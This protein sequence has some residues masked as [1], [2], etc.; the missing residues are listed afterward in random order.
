MNM[1][2]ISRKLRSQLTFLA[3]LFA[4]ALQGATKRQNQVH[5][6]VIS[7]EF[8][9]GEAP[10]LEFSQQLKSFLA[11]ND[12]TLQTTSAKIDFS[13][14][15]ALQEIR[16]LTSRNNP[17]VAVLQIGF[18]GIEAIVGSNQPPST[19]LKIRLADGL[20]EFIEA[21]RENAGAVVL[22]TPNPVR[23][24]PEL[25]ARYFSRH[26]NTL[27]PK[28]LNVLLRE[29]AQIMRNIAREMHVPLIDVFK[30]F[31]YLA[32]T[33]RDGALPFLK[34]HT[35]FSV[36][37]LLEN[38]A[39]P[40]TLGAQIIA[41]KLADKI[42]LV[43]DGKTQTHSFP[44][45]KE[46]GFSIPTIDLAHERHRQ[47][48]VDQ[49]P[50]QYLGHPTTVLLDD[51]QTMIAVYPKGHGR[52]GIVMKRSEDG[53]RTW[54]ERLPVPESWAASKEVPTIYKV[55]DGE[56]KRRLIMFSGLYPIMMAVSEDDGSTWSELKPIG[57]YGGIVATSSMVRLSNG[58][59]MTQFHDDGR[60]LRNGG[61]WTG[62]FDVFKILS[63]D[64]GLSWSEPELITHAP[65]AHLCEGGFVWSPDGKELAILLRE[66]SRQYN[67][68]VVFSQDEGKT[69]SQPQE[70]PGA[71]TGDRHVAKYAP[72][73]R[74][75]ITFRDRTSDGGSPTEGDWVGWIG[76]YEDLK[77]G[78]DGLYRVRLMDN[79]KD[80]D[81]CYPGLELLPNGEFVTTT[82]GHWTTGESPYIASVRFKMEE[83]DARAAGTT[84]TDILAIQSEAMEFI[85]A[86]ITPPE[87]WAAFRFQ[88]LADA[89]LSIENIPHS[90]VKMTKS[91][92]A[93]AD[94]TKMKASQ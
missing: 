77:H 55:Y 11:E 54:S 75:F 65:Y 64:G 89:N 63:K 83:I 71:L 31:E 39:R 87:G 42:M 16:S 4:V 46:R 13:T 53:G 69:W 80:W 78:R 84:L 91:L 90:L 49:E 88:Q 23:W 44:T 66:N 26:Y 7:T 52:G 48:I 18:H 59:Y 21:L 32:M 70:L 85:D 2:R 67:S 74:L 24:T 60:F 10:D 72:D 41:K 50:G 28:G 51:Q 15:G 36:D 6:Q 38:G 81:C 73:G 34:E 61:K 30:D 58:D 3:L 93:A 92:V 17:D 43:L 8:R 33:N 56:N 82:Y 57:E 20:R 1:R 12:F 47:V 37:D 27:A 62:K 86:K 68:F 9:D 45:G 35:P 14:P 22:M 76:G 40:N 94:S 25:K 19:Q 29:Y 79:T 5:V